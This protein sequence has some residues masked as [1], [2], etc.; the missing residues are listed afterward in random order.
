MPKI[1]KV[2]EFLQQPGHRPDKTLACGL[3]DASVFLQQ[4]YFLR[5]GTP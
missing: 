4:I 2:C 5:Y 1:E 3:L